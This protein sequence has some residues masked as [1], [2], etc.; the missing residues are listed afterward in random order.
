M[1][2]ASRRSGSDDLLS[3][4]VLGATQNQNESFN[5][6]IWNR[7]SKTDFSSPASVQ[8][9]VY[10]AILTFNE[11]EFSLLPIIKELGGVEPS[12][13]CQRLLAHAD[14]SRLYKSLRELEKKRR[15][16]Q[17]QSRLAYEEQMIPTEGVTYEY[18]GFDT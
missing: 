13:Y 5:G 6:L 1:H 12:P 18:G 7:C 15:Q 11:G 9:A 16:S 10:L 17:R 4:C 3:R 2:P 14:S 8:L